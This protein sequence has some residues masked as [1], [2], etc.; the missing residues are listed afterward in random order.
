MF[1]TNYMLTSSLALAMKTIKKFYTK[2]DQKSDLSKRNQKENRPVWC[3]AFRGNSFAFDFMNWIS[4]FRS[5]GDSADIRISLYIVQTKNRVL[6]NSSEKDSS[7]LNTIR[8]FI[9]IVEKRTKKEPMISTLKS[10]VYF[11]NIMSRQ[12]SIPVSIPM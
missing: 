10:I 6:S 1:I 7:N 3:K 8:A 11:V 9:K 2:V 12:I 4:L 5:S